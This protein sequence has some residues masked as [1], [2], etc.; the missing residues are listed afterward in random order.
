MS[1]VMGSGTSRSA[2]A[3]VQRPPTECEGFFFFFLR[4]R[5]EVRERGGTTG[6]R[7]NE[8]AQ[9]PLSFSFRS[10]DTASRR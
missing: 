10:F 1:P 6:D 8:N 7:K 5:V 9:K 4:E 3:R 2:A